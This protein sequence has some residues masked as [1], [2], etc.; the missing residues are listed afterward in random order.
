MP[1]VDILNSFYHFYDNSN[2]NLRANKVKAAIDELALQSTHL[3]VSSTSNNVSIDINQARSFS[4]TLNEN[5]TLN[6]LNP[7]LT[8]QSV[9]ITLKLQQDSLGSLFTF[10]WPASFEWPGGIVPTLTTDPLAIDVFKFY[11]HTAGGTWYAYEVGKDF[12]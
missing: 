7:P 11:T 10:S 2:S 1:A 6:I 3:S 4:H 9:E 8:G 5:T 12:K